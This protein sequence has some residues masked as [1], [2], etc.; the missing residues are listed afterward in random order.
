MMYHLMRQQE[1]PGTIKELFKEEAK[2]K[3]STKTES[4]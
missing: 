1:I 3:P 2:T 4:D